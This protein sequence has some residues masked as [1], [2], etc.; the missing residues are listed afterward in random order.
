MNLSQKCQY[1]VRAVLELSKRHGRGPVSAAEIAASQAVPQRFLEI[2]L[3]ELKPTGILGSRRGAQ[4][5]FYLTV[6]P[7]DLTVGQVIRLVDGPLDPVRCADDQS[8]D[9]CPLI[10]HCA[11]TELW[12]QAREAVEGVYDNVTFLHLIEKERDLEQRAALHYQI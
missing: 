3:N 12:K 8:V 9:C 10:G 4:G 7:A 2:I 5:G 6:P 11:L 1:A